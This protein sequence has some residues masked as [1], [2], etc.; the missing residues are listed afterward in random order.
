MSNWVM[1]LYVITVVN[2]HGYRSPNYYYDGDPIAYYSV[3]DCEAAL[4]KH[5][6]TYD[7]YG[8]AQCTPFP[9]NMGPISTLYFCRGCTEEQSAAAMKGVGGR[10]QVTRGGWQCDECTPTQRRSAL[11]GVDTAKPTKP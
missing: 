8:P 3:A 4:K 11:V 10:V 9:A 6:P 1:V 2:Q 5:P 7:E